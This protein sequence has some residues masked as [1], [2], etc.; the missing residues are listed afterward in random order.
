[1]PST[2]LGE[3]R[4]P[5]PVRTIL[6]TIGLVLATA[7]ALLLL[8]EVRRTLVWLVVAVFFTIA[9]YPL[10]N[11]LDDALMGITHVL[12]GEDL[13]PSTPRQ[14]VLYRALGVPPPAFFH[15]PLVLG[16]DGGRLAKRHGSPSIA[17]YRSS[18]IA[19]ERV[20]GMLAQSLDLVDG[21]TDAVSPIDLIERFA[22]LDLNRISRE[23]TLLPAPT[24]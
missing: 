24:A 19:P 15:V 8:Y 5:V 14:L 23:P 4:R 21:G 12:R 13:L 2:A 9:L 20:M 11:P 7:A 6:A 22:R 18:G 16:P 3:P 10:T 17:E 1:M